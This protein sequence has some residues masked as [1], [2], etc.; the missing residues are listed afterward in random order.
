[1]S[2]DWR[3]PA[4]LDTATVGGQR[5]IDRY[6]WRV[7]LVAAVVFTVLLAGM[8]WR[9]APSWSPVACAVLV[10]SCI[11]AFVRPSA[12]VYLIVVLTMI[13]D[14]IIWPWWPFTKNLSSRESILF[15]N[16]AVIVNPLELVM[17]VTF[18]SFFVRRMANPL[19]RFRRD[20]LFAPIM[21]FTGFVVAGF[22]RGQASGADRRIAIFEGR[23]LFYI[24][25]I[26]VLV[27]NL[28]WSRT[29]I[30]AAAPADVHGDRHPERV[31][32]E[33]LR[34]SAGRE[35]GGDRGAGR[36]R[37]CRAHGRRR[38]VPDGPGPDARNPRRVMGIVVMTPT[39]LTAF[40]LSERRAAMVAL[41]IGIAVVAYFTYHRR[42][43][44]FWFFV[45]V[46]V[47][48]GSGFVA[49]TWGADG[50]IGLPAQAVQSV[51]APD[52]LGAAEQSSNIYREVEALNLNLTIRADP[53]A[54]VGFGRTFS[55]FYPMPDI[56]F[57]EFWAFKPHNSILWIWLK[58]GFLGF[59]S[60]WFMFGR[61]IQH[62][63][64]AALQV[65][66]RNQALYVATAVASLVMILVYSYV[67]IG[68][69]SRS[70]VLTGVCFALCSSFASARDTRGSERA[71]SHT[72]LATAG[73]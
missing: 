17:L 42:R 58:M 35:E 36:A 15:V 30:S 2:R 32:A 43:R 72:H 61:A 70:T 8:G 4:E 44:A 49:A 69:D 56:S 62:G 1:M 38:R 71:R 11:A 66:P 26:Y 7:I 39:I 12:G 59:V 5:G 50:A 24:A 6:Q 3:Y 18:F 41:F 14:S 73:R 52:A 19:W 68:W 21:V 25:V 31:R 54:G 64:R 57:Y 23:S 22:L 47:I 37:Q 40:F 27:T 51:I 46:A 29:A 9:S 33:V 55:V 65:V 20:A 45:P 67:D 16:D 53:I 60:M 63:T 13:G 48:L 10:V 28:F 34:R